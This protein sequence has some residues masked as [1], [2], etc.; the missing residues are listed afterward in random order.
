MEVIVALAVGLMTGVGIYLVLRN[1]TYPVILGLVMLTY[2]IN[3]FLFS[4]G[5]LA[6]DQAPIV[7]AETKTMTDPV[8]QALV[9][10][11]IVISFGTTALVVVLALRAFLETDDDRVSIPDTAIDVSVLTKHLSCE[12]SQGEQSALGQSTRRHEIP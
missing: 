1:R 12:Q 8:P 10:T 2:A 3:L 9:L 7:T 6:I 5:G 11:A 4:S